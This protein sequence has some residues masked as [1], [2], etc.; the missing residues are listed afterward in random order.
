MIE[1]REVYILKR[2]RFVINN[3][4]HMRV[5]DF[6]GINLEVRLAKREQGHYY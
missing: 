6:D 3:Y 4:G 5:G 2:L 1:T